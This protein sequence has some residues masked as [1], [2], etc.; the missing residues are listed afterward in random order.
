[1]PTRSTSAGSG[2]SKLPNTVEAVKE[3]VL[4]ARGALKGPPVLGVLF[5]S[6]RHELRA[7]LAQARALAGCEVVGCHT[8]GEF[9]EAGATRGGLALLLV[10]STRL[11]TQVVAARGVGASPEEVARD[12]G[13]PYAALE[14]RARSAGLGLSTTLLLL[15]GLAGSPE[16]LVQELLKHTRLF[17]QVVG[18]AAGDGGQ[19][20]A[21][22]AGGPGLD[23]SDVAAA[24][25]VFDAHPW[26]IGVDHG[27]T[28][29]GAPLTVTESAGRT[30]QTLDHRPAFEVYSRAAEAA[31]QAL[32]R[33]SA[34][35]HLITH[36]LG[37]LFLDEVRRLRAAMGAG[38][39]GELRLLA[40]L[41]EGE[42][43]SI[44]EATADSLV[45]AAG[46][47]ADEARERLGGT[48]AAGVLVFDCLARGMV[49]GREFQREIDAVRAVF[50]QVPLAGLLGYG[51]VARYRS[52]REGWHTGA[53]VV[54]A[55]PA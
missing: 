45:A 31:G 4:Q 24:A 53:V 11:M 54:A 21:T 41:A 23:G 44:M 6:P 7:A 3:A 15:D 10:A 29:T 38:P 36:P 9:T 22:P 48:P 2:G 43:V 49:L 50:P 33:E 51:Q 17:Q 46:R 8:A 1:M 13:A 34:G 19:F 52:P 55:I 18:G 47:A 25:H 32:V 14:A 12:L 30:V 27:F 40:P 42:Q 28:P 39:A 16:V 35:P 37:V 20:Q 26:G 5:A